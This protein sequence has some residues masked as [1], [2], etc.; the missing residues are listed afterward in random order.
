MQTEGRVIIQAAPEELER[1]IT[2]AVRAARREEEEAAHAAR[3]EEK[4]NGEGPDQH[5]KLITP[6]DIQKEFGIH[7]KL[8]AYWRLQ[9]MGPAYV[10]FGRRIYYE[11]PAFE[12][13][14]ASARVQTTGWVEK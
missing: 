13:F 3:C 12:Q 5:K 14:V 2:S 4:E 8:L 9:G 1:L 10:T 7:R 11:R 6:I